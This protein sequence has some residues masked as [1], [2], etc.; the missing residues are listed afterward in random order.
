LISFA[1]TGGDHVRIE[2]KKAGLCKLTLHPVVHLD[3]LLTPA[4][5]RRIG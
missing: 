4:Q 2:L 1:L 5:M 3:W